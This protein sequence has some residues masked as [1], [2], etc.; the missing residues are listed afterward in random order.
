[1]LTRAQFANAIQTG[2][3]IRQSRAQINPL[4]GLHLR[5][6]RT[7]SGAAGVVIVVQQPTHE[8]G[9]SA[10][11]GVVAAQYGK[12]GTGQLKLQILLQHIAQLWIEQGAV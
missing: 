5:G 8:P 2:A 11:I 10:K 4:R 6:Q 12:P 1:M 7:N 9:L 3:D